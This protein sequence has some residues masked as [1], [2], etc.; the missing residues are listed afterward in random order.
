MADTIGKINRTEEKLL[1]A[2]LEKPTIA[3]AAAAAGL[4]ETSVYRWLRN[5]AFKERY[6][7]ARRQIMAGAVG[8]L[9]KATGTAVKTLIEVMDSPTAPP[10]AKVSAARAILEFG[11]EAVKIEDIVDQLKKLDELEKEIAALTMPES[12][13]GGRH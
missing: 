3:D 8:A 2:L 6:K 11:F 13:K 4:S 12:M 10:A 7:E 9:Q 5:P 1:I